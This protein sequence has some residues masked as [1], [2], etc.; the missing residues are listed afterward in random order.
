MRIDWVTHR[1]LEGHF[2]GNQVLMQWLG[3]RQYYFI[4]KSINWLKY[5]RCYLKLVWNKKFEFKIR[6]SKNG[7]FCRFNRIYRWFD[8][9]FRMIWR[10]IPAH[11]ASRAYIWDSNFLWLKIA[12]K[13]PVEGAF[14]R[15]NSCTLRLRNALKKREKLMQAYQRRIFGAEGLI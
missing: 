10:L 4:I 3:L 1:C 5:N 14:G 6:F 2:K 13:H 15:L 8:N 7:I 12:V 9:N 11:G